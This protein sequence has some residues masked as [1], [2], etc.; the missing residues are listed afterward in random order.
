MLKMLD[1]PPVWLGISLASVWSMG[2]LMPV[3]LF[4]GA[5]QWAGAGL[6]LA[7]CLLMGLAVLEMWRARTTVI[8]HR[9]PSALVTGGVFRFSRNPIY[10]GDSLLLL[11]AVVWFDAVAGIIMVPLFMKLIEKRFIFGEEARMRMIFG[12]NFDS[13]ASKVRR[14]V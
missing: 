10:L 1:L 5:A 7:G 11:G 14:W 2:K 6:A 12:E 8:P 13:W 4:G 9:S 3:S